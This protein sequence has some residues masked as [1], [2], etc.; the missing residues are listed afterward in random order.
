MMTLR[1][2]LYATVSLPA[3][4]AGAL[5]YTM[6]LA[7][8]SDAKWQFR[9]AVTF[10]VAAVLFGCVTWSVHSVQELVR[11]FIRLRQR[12]RDLEVSHDNMGQTVNSRLATQAWHAAGMTGTD[13]RHLWVVPERPEEN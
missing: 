11:E 10:L 13:A 7:E 6:S 1:N 5:F 2:K 8:G 4:L 9:M 3:G 12:V